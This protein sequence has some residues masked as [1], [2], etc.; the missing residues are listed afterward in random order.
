LT[1]PIDAFAVLY[2]DLRLRAWGSAEEYKFIF[3][4]SENL[5]NLL[6]GNVKIKT[7]TNKNMQTNI[8]KKWDEKQDGN[9]FA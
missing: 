9:C 3:L 2:I 5:L 7:D 8:C 1:V 6:L 4:F